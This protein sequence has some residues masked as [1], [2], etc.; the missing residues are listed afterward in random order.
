MS[1]AL[2]ALLSG[3][4]LD[5]LLGEPK[6]YHP[7][8]GFGNCANLL[9]KHFNTAHSTQAWLSISLGG[10]AWGLLVLPLP[11]ALAFMRL[12]DTF[13]N[14][15]DNPWLTGLIDASIIYLCIGYT[16]LKQ[17]ALRVWLALSQNNLPLARR[18]VGKIVSRETANLNPLSVRRAAIESVLENGLDAIFAALFW[19][20]L[21][22]APGIVLYRLANTLDAMWGY[23]NPR[24]FYFGRISARLDDLLNWL[25]AR[26]VA[27]SYA[28]LG[29]RKQAFAAWQQQARHCASPNGGPVMTAG[30][31]ALA[32][33]L[34]GEAIYHGKLVNK[35]L[36]GRGAAPSNHDIP[37]AL[38]LVSRTLA[39]W[40]AVYAGF[41]MAVVIYGNI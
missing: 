10:L 36:M 17:H 24:F 15:L 27:L 9:E 25:P 2:A 40:C 13:D 29:Q 34:G 30:A 23:K 21:A 38:S 1:T 28:L 4:L 6:R 32:I 18:E 35:P 33:T 3:V 37:R 12:G 26:G 5:M 31:G 7:L 11:L 19:F 41:T 14:P 16:S 22:G 8:V 39:L 20:M